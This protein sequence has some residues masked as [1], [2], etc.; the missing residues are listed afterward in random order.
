MTHG[1][2]RSMGDAERWAPD[3][4]RDLHVCQR[5]PGCFPCQSARLPVI[6]VGLSRS[7]MGWCSDDINH[8]H[9]DR[10]R[11]TWLHQLGVLELLSNRYQLP[12][13]SGVCALFL[14]GSACALV[15]YSVSLAE[16]MT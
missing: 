10:Q 6:R 15:Q 8:L 11:P 2:V 14:I 13:K 3:V 9:P 1:S 4:D 7:R 12:P 5:S 16:L